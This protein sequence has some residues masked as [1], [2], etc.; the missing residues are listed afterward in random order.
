MSE[1]NLNNPTP[2]AGEPWHED[3]KLSTASRKKL[4]GST[5]CGPG[6]SFPVPDCA[7]VTAARRL[8]G[9]YKGSGSH[10]SILSCVSRKSKALGCG[11]KDNLTDEQIDKMLEDSE[12]DESKELMAFLDYSESLKKVDEKK[13][14]SV[15]EGACKLLDTLRAKRLKIPVSQDRIQAYMARGLESIMDALLDELGD[16]QE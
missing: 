1:S 6:R 4:K 16:V 7:H 14:D 2:L 13:A 9:R 12:W 10:A 3:A 15:K 8:I 11:G 5:F